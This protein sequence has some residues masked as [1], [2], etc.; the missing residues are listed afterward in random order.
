MKQRNTH[1][2]TPARA[3]NYLLSLF[4]EGFYTEMRSIS[5]EVTEDGVFTKSDVS[6]FTN[7]ELVNVAEDIRYQIRCEIGIF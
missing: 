2:M 3:K 5:H 7:E 1:T 4:D 6:K